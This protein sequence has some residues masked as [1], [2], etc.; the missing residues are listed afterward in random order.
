MNGTWLDQTIRP[1]G[2]PE[3]DVNPATGEVE[4]SWALDDQSRFTLL[5]ERS[6]VEKL[7]ASLAKV[8]R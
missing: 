8:T 1:G 2:E 5:L 4:L 6:V 3:V 7:P